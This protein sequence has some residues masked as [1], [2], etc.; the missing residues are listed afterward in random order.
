MKTKKI[1]NLADRVNI[2]FTSIFSNKAQIILFV[3][4]LIL[5][6]WLSFF[7]YNTFIKPYL[8]KKHSLNKEFIKNS[9]GT[10]KEPITIF[11]FGTEWCPYCKKAK[12]EW[13][14]FSNYVKSFNSSNQDY[15]VTLKYIDCDEDTKTAEKYNIKGYPTIK[16]IRNNKIYEYDARPNS[17]NLIEFLKTSI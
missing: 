7:S 12:P 5:F 1:S 3:I 6:A 8:E 15:E 10:N 17:D 11:M 2:L 9:G 16:L 4:A 13:D 14:K